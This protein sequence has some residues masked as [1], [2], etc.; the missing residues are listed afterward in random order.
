M[1]I[2]KSQRQIVKKLS[3]LENRFKSHN[4]TIG[5]CAADK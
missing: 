5:R 4:V 1:D 2:R 3:T